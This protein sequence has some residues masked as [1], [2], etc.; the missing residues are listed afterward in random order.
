MQA[1]TVIRLRRRMEWKVRLM[2]VTMTAGSYSSILVSSTR[3][4]MPA[5]QKTAGVSCMCCMR[6]VGRPLLTWSSY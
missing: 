4:G 3:V 2:S 5:Q 6:C 1:P